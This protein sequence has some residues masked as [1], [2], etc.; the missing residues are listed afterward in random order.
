MI[1]NQWNLHHP[2]VPLPSST[3]Q[4]IYAYKRGI[5]QQTHTVYHQSDPK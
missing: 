5:T 4:D 2:T 1:K 3:R